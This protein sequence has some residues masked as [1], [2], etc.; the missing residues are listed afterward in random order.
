[1]WDGYF[2][3]GGNEVGNSA[4][5][6]GYQRTAD[7]PIGWIRDKDCGGIQSM[8]DDQGAYIYS[9]INEAPWY[10]TD[11]PDLSSR[12]LG[13]YVIE[14]QGVSDST[15]SAVV[16]EKIT[17]G[18]QVSGYRHTSRQVRVRALL[19]GDGMDALEYGMTWLR[20]VLEPNACGVH[21]GDCGASDFQ[22]FVDCPPEWD[23]IEPIEDYW[24]T[25]AKLRR[26]LHTVTCIS[27]P[28]VQE[29]K[30]SSDKRH[31][32]YIVEFTLLAAVPFVYGAT[33]DIDVPPITPTIVQDVAYNLLT[34]PSAELASG[35]AL[36][37]TNLSTNPSVETD[38]TGWAATSDGTAITNAML[39][40][41]RVTGEL[42]AVGVA[43]YRVVFTATGAG[44]NGWFG[45]QQQVTIPT[46]A[47][48]RFSINM[49]A[50][51]VLMTGS[52]VRG[53]LDIFAYWRNGTTNLRTD[54][55]GS[56]PINGG[57]L[58]TP[59]IAPP[60]TADNVVVRAIARMTSW[61]SGNVVRL[62]AD[63]LAVTNP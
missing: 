61:S 11:D 58:S 59:N 19:T 36:V 2:S 44:T 12:F 50:A 17:D 47:G 9:R 5:A 37:Q 51:E 20:N 28:L 42:A 48:L 40:S 14:M 32:A 29:Q 15:R 52:P 41:G 34:H 3:L 23:Q 56:V 27:G 26:V 10:D 6:I 18:A 54:D 30:V 53:D 25:N 57:A 63:A 43:S 38:A 62:Y 46:T 4:R 21:G 16:T 35:L 22:F 39:T 45:A 33:R 31:Y 8:V 1:M 13:L 49:W 24:D 55:L 7:C 60:A